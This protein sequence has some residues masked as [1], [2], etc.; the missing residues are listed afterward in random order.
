MS[1]N[2]RGPDPVTPTV[3]F[4]SYVIPKRK[5]PA[6]PSAPQAR[7]PEQTFPEEPV[8]QTHAQP[9]H[10]PEPPQQTYAEPPY[11]PE[12]AHQAYV[13]PEFLPE[14]PYQEYSQP[15]YPAEAPYQEYAPSERPPEP[16]A[17]AP[18]AMLQDFRVTPMMVAA[19]VI[20]VLTFMLGVVTTLLIMNFAPAPQ[21]SFAVVPNAE[22]GQHLGAADGSEPVFELTP[23]AALEVAVEASLQSDVTRSGP[24]DLIS[25]VGA[26]SQPTGDAIS[27]AEILL[28]LQPT[29][30]ALPADAVLDEAVLNRDK[31][32][33]L[34]DYVLAGQYT[35]KAVER[36]GKERLCLQ[37]P[38]GSVTP[39]EAADLIREAA[40][41]GEIELP[42]AVSTADG[43]FDADTLLFNLVQTS[44]A[45]DGTVQ[46]AEAAREMSRRAF[47]A[48]N[49]K[50]RE[51]EGE[52]VYIVEP[53][54]S[55]AYISLQFYG[56]PSDYDRI[57][58]A[59]RQI[60]NSPDKIQIGQRLIIPG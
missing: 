52:R 24:A 50:T 5:E 9:V 53:G 1:N 58:Q 31:L 16:A 38:D 34:R 45:N 28:G 20:A 40:E 23:S 60:L 51:I 12:P 48:S 13:Q 19:S 27:M 22:G 11:R 2:R 26:M 59:N 37:I 54:D 21:A 3:T 55:L 14:P 18:L 15:E 8:Q 6:A 32:T 4:D 30:N 46:G 42:Q 56:Q 41:R 7:Q 17:A 43:T 10:P 29:A 57:F 33:M 36:Y 49:A 47:A 35:V 25:P 39:G 44:L